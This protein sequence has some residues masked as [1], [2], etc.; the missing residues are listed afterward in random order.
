MVL[1]ENGIHGREECDHEGS[2]SAAHRPMHVVMWLAFENT[3]CTPPAVV[4]RL[5]ALESG[6]FVRASAA[7]KCRRPKRAADHVDCDRYLSI[8][9]Q[10]GVSRC[11]PPRARLIEEY[12]RQNPPKLGWR[13]EWERPKGQ[14]RVLRL[15]EGRVHG[16][17][18][19]L[20]LRP[21]LIECGYETA[22]VWI[23]HIV[24]HCRRNA[25]GLGPIP[26]RK[27]ELGVAA[28][29]AQRDLQPP[30]ISAMPDQKPPIS[31]RTIE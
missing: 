10:I 31:M 11:Q 24:E 15:G 20:A 25:R 13:R 29:I 2:S 28:E 14:L 12:L 8:G 21:E 27:C 23:E 5:C 22:I 6:R 9:V 30:E 1:V 18:C 17:D 7:G 19:G 3:L 4:C 16:G 26:V